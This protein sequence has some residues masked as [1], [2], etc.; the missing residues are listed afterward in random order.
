MLKPVLALLLIFGLS[1]PAFAA[2][3]V[4]SDASL[5]Q[6]LEVTEA[7]KLFDTSLQQADS[8][9]QSGLQQQLGN[10]QIN[11]EQQR[12]FDDYRSQL[13]VMLRQAISW[14]ILEPATMDIYR[15]NFTQQEINDLLVFYRSEAGQ[16]IIHKMPLITQASMKLVQERMAMVVPQFQS[17]NQDFISKFQAAA[18]K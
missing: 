2:D 13:L 11:A 7:H 10:M 15:K 9:M 4:P 1:A 6:L 5:R 17:L 16:A 18:T 3:D 14:E 8:M 12:I